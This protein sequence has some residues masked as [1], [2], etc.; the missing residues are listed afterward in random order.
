M[1]LKSLRRVWNAVF[2]KTFWVEAD[3][4][5]F[6]ILTYKALS[7]T[8][9]LSLPNFLYRNPD[10]EFGSFFSFTVVSSIFEFKVLFIRRLQMQNWFEYC[11][12]LMVIQLRQL[13]MLN[14]ILRANDWNL[15]YLK[16]NTFLC[17]NLNASFLVLMKCVL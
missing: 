9:E 5:K 16:V 7:R 3:F 6:M 10:S 1:R 13:S 17:N 8:K 2:G 14:F 12:L 4:H 15:L 11:L